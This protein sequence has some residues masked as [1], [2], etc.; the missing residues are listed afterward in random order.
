VSVWRTRALAV[1]LALNLGL[2]VVWGVN[3]ARTLAASTPYFD[4]PALHGGWVLA[5]ERPGARLYDFGAQG[6]V[7]E[8]LLGRR[9]YAQGVLPFVHPPHAALAL[10][11]LGWLSLRSAFLAWTAAQ[12]GML[13]LV[14]WQVRRLLDGRPPAQRWLAASVVLGFPPCAM[15]IW[16]GQV[17]LL[18]LVALLGF[19]LSLRGDRPRAAAACLLVA[20]IKPQLLPF[21]LLA[22]VVL[23]R[24]RVLRLFALGLGAA[25]AL[26]ALALGPGA[27]PAFFAA[28]ARLLALSSEAG[29][30]V[31]AM[32]NLRGLLTAALGEGARA[33]IAAAAGVALLLAAAGFVALG[34]RLPGDP[35]ARALGLLA[36]AA[37]LGAFF[38]PH[39]FV[40]DDVLYLLAAGL[41]CARPAPPPSL[42]AF[43]VAL[44]G[45]FQLVLPWRA[46]PAV[47]VALG[48]VLAWALSRPAP[49][50]S[51]P[52]R[53]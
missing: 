6:A 20:S 8:R 52:A 27:W 12:L 46:T 7:Q 38:S 45:L 31:Q 16:F 3:V 18:V 37:W 44:P 24:W 51:D 36:A 42:L 48:V 23:G 5:L 40:Q 22:V 25:V 30:P 34:R 17:S 28:A 39:L 1:V 35:P 41:A 33:G 21:P 26:S 19:A 11:P 29:L 50:P 2:A 49:G 13:A 53:R 10:A 14:L 43:A 15:A 4:F 47:V 32:D 9:V